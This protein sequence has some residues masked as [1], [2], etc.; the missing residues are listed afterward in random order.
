MKKLALTVA[1]LGACAASHA[2]SAN[3]RLFA[4]A[5]IAN[6]AETIFSG[7]I[8]TDGSGQIVPF[9]VTAGG[10]TQYRF[11]ADYRVAERITL[12]GSVG[13]HTDDP[14]GYNGSVTFS[15]TP[16][17]LLAF[18]NVSDALR[19][20]GGARQSFAKMAATG[21]VEKWSGVGTYDSTVGSVAELQ[22]L[23]AQDEGK[24]AHNRPQ[25]GI[26]ARWVNETF[27]HSASTFSGDHYELGLVLYY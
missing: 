4:G 12:Q 5:G 1:I 20:G 8:T 11:G 18:F 27:T 13:F 26:S 9:Q 21:K 19:I 3:W 10:G 2:E 15:N 24:S 17:E 16:V 7:T 22:Y 14:M 25:F 6:G 23:F